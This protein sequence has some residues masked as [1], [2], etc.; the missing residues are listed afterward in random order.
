MADGATPLPDLPWTPSDLQQW[1][2]T[3]GRPP[4]AIGD[5]TDLSYDDSELS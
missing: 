1:R 2:P 4:I 5:Y 3:S